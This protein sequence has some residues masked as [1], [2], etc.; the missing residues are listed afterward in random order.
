MQAEGCKQT[1][2]TKRRQK[3]AVI[4]IAKKRLGITDK[5][6]RALLH[7]AAGVQ[8]A[9]DL[10]N[11]TQYFTLMRAFRAASCKSRRKH[12]AKDEGLH[13][14][15]AQ[16]YYIRGLWELASRSKTERSLRVMIKRICNVDDLSFLSKAGATKVILALRDIA[17]KAGFNPDRKD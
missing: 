2:L 11:D 5:N 14:T 7:E 17:E 4:H 13:C 3:L 15:K 16:H 12:P 9:A 6:Y 8:S 1:M 10:R